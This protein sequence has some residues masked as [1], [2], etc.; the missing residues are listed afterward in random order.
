MTFIKPDTWEPSPGIQLDAKALEIVKSKVPLSISA[1]PGTGKTE[2]LAQRANFLLATGLC[3]SPQRILAIAFKTDAARNLSD[4]VEERSGPILAQRFDSLTLDA[5]A[6]RIIDQ[7]VEALPKQWRPSS[8]YSII[9]PNKD[10]WEDFRQHNANEYPRIKEVRDADIDSIVH[11]TTLNM[12]NSGTDLE[13]HIRRLWWKEQIDATPSRLTFGMI[14]IMAAFILRKQPS[15]LSA[16]QHTYSHVFLDEFQ[17]VT[18]LQYD[19]I[20]AAFLGSETIL[21]AVGDS[22][23]AI[24]R[25]AGAEERIFHKFE[26]DFGAKN[27]RLR[28]N[29][30]SNSRIVKLLNDLEG[31][32]DNSHTPTV[33]MRQNSPIP[34]DA[35]KALIFNTRQSEGEFLAHFI[36][37]DIQK[38]KAQKRK[39]SDFV[40]LTRIRAGDVENRLKGIFQNV[41]LTLRNEARQ[42]GGIAIQDLVREQIYLFLLASLKLAVDVRNG[43]PFEDCRNTIADLKGVDLDNEKGYH[44]V[45][46]A[47]RQLIRELKTWI[48]K[49]E[50]S[51][52]SG[53][54]LS[55]I[56]L[57]HFEPTKFQ[58]VYKEYTSSERLYSAIS[59]FQAFFDECCKTATS[60]PRC[61][62]NMEGEDSVRLMTIHRSKGL[63]Y[64]T[65][66]FVELNDDSFWGNEDDMKVFFVA[67]S[68]AR[69]R[70]YF[71]LARDSRGFEN[72]K[73]YTD[74]LQTAEVPFEQLS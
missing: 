19:L 35:I 59:G 67:L 50:F 54:E 18:G 41:N 22:N 47:M 20:K 38:N 10:I 26:S 2:L 32:F 55:S 5:F 65:V 6:K 39:S 34:E 7:F 62:S 13:K 4:R 23:Q 51:K 40:I 57:T 43:Q 14:K 72:V 21:T 68:R 48:D 73:R 42:V 3:L 69:E 11:E 74:M 36:C 44:K 61:I 31:V 37:N 60:L 52:I 30:R 24:M 8:N 12:Q 70:V 17:D 56:I 33:C 63:E 66:F 29:F 25:W 45:S 27:E 49:Q 9:F 15:I 64:H 28:F 58:R 46:R 71:S 53:Q 16:L 1:G